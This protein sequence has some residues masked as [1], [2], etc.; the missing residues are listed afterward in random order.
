[1]LD[2]IQEKVAKMLKDINPGMYADDWCWNDDETVVEFTAMEFRGIRNGRPVEVN[3]GRYRFV[4]KAD[5]VF[6][7]SA[8]EQVADWLEKLVCRF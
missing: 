3:H 1:M 4:Y 5:D 2:M 6:E 7:R 8:K